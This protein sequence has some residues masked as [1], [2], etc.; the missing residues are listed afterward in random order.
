MRHKFDLQIIS[1]DAL[2]IDRNG[3]DSLI[4]EEK[5]RE[6]IQGVVTQSTVLARSRKLPN[7]ST[8]SY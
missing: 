8:K 6:I 3:S 2:I 7:M 1:N 5:A 4:P